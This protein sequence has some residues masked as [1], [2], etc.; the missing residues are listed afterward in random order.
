MPLEGV[1]DFEVEFAFCAEACEPGIHQVSLVFIQGGVG[2]QR[3]LNHP[4]Y[5]GHE[6]PIS[7]V[8]SHHEFAVAEGARYPVCVG[9]L[10]AP[11]VDFLNQGGDI[12]PLFR[13]EGG[14]NGIQAFRHPVV[15]QKGSLVPTGIGQAFKPGNNSRC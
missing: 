9:V 13:E 3:A 14:E 7:F 6:A 5:K 15:F 8:I 1:G 2:C 4:L 12:G 10:A 11:I